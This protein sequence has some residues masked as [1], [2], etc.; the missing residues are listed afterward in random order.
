MMFD[1][2]KRVVI[3]SDYS[4]DRKNIVKKH[5]KGLKIADINRTECMNFLYN[6]L[7]HDM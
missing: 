2:V 6:T 5:L 4:L 3:L 1:L 7:S